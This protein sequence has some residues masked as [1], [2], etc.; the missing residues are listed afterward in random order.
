MSAGARRS[1]FSDEIEIAAPRARLHAFLLDLHNH[2]ELHPLIVSIEDLPPLPEAPGARRYRIVDRVPF[3]PLRL[4]AEYVAAIEPV[5]G[6]EIRAEAWQSP[7]IHLETS[8]RLQD[9]GEATLLA[10]HVSVE[11][12]RGLRGFVTRQASRAHH[13][14]LRKMQAHFRAAKA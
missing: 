11:A 5:S 7:G 14:T 3:G 1:E 4:R 2:L 13:E 8:Y 9:R 6:H 10:E 12:P